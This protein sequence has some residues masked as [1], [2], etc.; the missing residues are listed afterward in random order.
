MS[1]VRFIRGEEYPAARGIWNV[2][3]PEDAGAYGDYYFAKRTRPEWVVGAFEGS[4][5]M[6]CLHII[7]EIITVGEDELPVGMI[8]GVGTLPEYRKRG[9]AAELLAFAKEYLR[10]QGAYGAMLQPVDT[11]YY[12]SSGFAPY[13][14]K[15]NYLI[16][17]GEGSFEEG[18]APE[19][20]LGI[21]RRYAAGY[22]GMRARGP[23]EMALLMEEWRLTGCRLAV[24]EGAYAAYYIKDGMAHT[25]ELAGE[26]PLPL[27]RAIAAAEGGVRC[28]LPLAQSAIGEKT[29]ERVFTMM[30]WLKEPRETRP[31]CSL[32][33]C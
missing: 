2:C 25:T 10:G 3:F 26:E 19:E 22:D 1:E 30:A 13:C 18:A 31:V 12:I 28:E 16:S 24:K 21:Y 11:A 23:E 33:Y 29:G 15:G 7:P 6:A 27:L 14:V 4:R 17:H 9:L 20:L 32:E 8:A 5:L